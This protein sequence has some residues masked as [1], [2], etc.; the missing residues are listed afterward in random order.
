MH[1]HG[2]VI[3]IGKD[4]PGSQHEKVRVRCLRCGEQFFREYKHVHLP[5]TC[6]T[7]LP[8]D[9][10]F[11]EGSKW[12][13]GCHEYA[14]TSHFACDPN[15]FDNLATY[16]NECLAD[17]KLEDK[18]IKLADAIRDYDCLLQPSQ[19]IELFRAQRGRCYYSKL[20]MTFD[21]GMRSVAVEFL[22]PFRR[23]FDDMVLVC[24]AF[25]DDAEELS[26]VLDVIQSRQQ[27]TRLETKIIHEGGQ[28]PFRKRTSDAGYDVHSVE[29]LIIQPNTSASVDTGIIVSPPEGAYY[30]IEGRSSVFSAG[31]TPYR[32]I[33]DGTYQGPLKVIL[34]NN[35]SNSYTVRRGDR[36]AQLILHP[37]VNGD[38]IVV[39]EFT[40]VEN[41]R[42]DSGWGSSGK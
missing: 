18:A 10:S 27:H 5:H 13:I 29:E 40:P 2:Q 19:I 20:P 25:I 32:G 37:I 11:V 30:T 24:K 42:M 15:S 38:F 21:D 16:C 31:V 8:Y 1:G 33:I 35:S 3:I 23:H 28:L 22:N 9:G 41:G 34:M 12:C 7:H 4:R 6:P 39:D 26:F 17:N 14:P 36:I